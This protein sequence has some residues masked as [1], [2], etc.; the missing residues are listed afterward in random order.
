MPLLKDAFLACAGIFADSPVP[1]TPRLN[2]AYYY[3][4]ATS[5][6]GT[7]RSFQI[8]S[9]GDTS[10]YLSLALAVLTFNIHVVGGSAFRLCRYTLPALQSLNDCRAEI[11]HDDFAF[12]ICILHT[13]LEGCLFRN[14]V[15]SFRFQIRPE[16]FM[17][18]YLGLSAP[19]LS[20][21]YDLC[22][23]STKLHQAD[24]N[25]RQSLL[26]QLQSLE[27]EISAWRPTYPADFLSRYSQAEVAHMLS[28]VQIFRQ[29]LLLIAHRLR[30]PFGTC[31]DRSE[32]LSD[33]ILEQFDSISSLVNRTVVSMDFA[34][35]VAAFEV[36]DPAKRKDVL[37]KVS[38][39]QDLPVTYQTRLKSILCTFWETADEKS[40]L[41]WFDLDRYLAPYL[42]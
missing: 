11:D 32:V 16:G 30:H 39:F 26:V 17:N 25:G 38:L 28:Q 36:R 37:D 14:E 20:Y 29:S 5:G 1:G 4:Q 7:F 22:V 34:L 19:L 8:T 24:E 2:E 41:L 6:L 18:R 27:A 12:L 13:E 33:M 3:Q 35:L 10:L 23:L 42:D 21:G 40:G 9:A 15:P 31:V